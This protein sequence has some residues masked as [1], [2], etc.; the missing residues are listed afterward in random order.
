MIQ[1]Q[2]IEI[3]DM[4]FFE[5]YRILILFNE[6]APPALKEVSIIH[7]FQSEPPQSLLAKGST[8]IF[9]DQEYVVEKLGELANQTLHDLGHASLY[10]GLDDSTELLPGAILLHPYRLPELRVGDTIKFIK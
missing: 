8:I 1:S 7:R 2:I 5:D 10:F 4:A 9:N 6:T 3:G